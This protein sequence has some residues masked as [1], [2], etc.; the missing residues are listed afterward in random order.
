MAPSNSSSDNHNNS[1]SSSSSSSTLLDLAKSTGATGSS[2]SANTDNGG[3][4]ETAQWIERL[5]E[6][7]GIR[8]SVRQNK[9][10]WCVRESAMWGIA[11]G[12]AMTLHRFRMSS[13]TQFASKIGFATIMG[14]YAG[15]YYFC[16]K[17]RDYQEQMIQLMMRLNTFDHAVDM[18][19]Q[20]PMDENHPFVAPITHTDTDNADSN[21]L[22]NVAPTIQYVAKL[23]ERKEWQKQLPIQQELSQVFQEEE[24]SSD[25]KK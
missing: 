10:R 8:E 24:Q 4:V 2:N 23:P 11:T 14:I 22:A 20:R 5:P 13:H 18:P 3:V 15:S 19:A 16:V 7:F 25:K 17:R 21:A 9:Y 1:T 12:T 6:A